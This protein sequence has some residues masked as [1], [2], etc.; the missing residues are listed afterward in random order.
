[1]AYYLDKLDSVFW[2]T[3][4]GLFFAFL[5]VVLKYCF[6]SKCR[7]VL[8]CCFYI[9]RDIEAEIEEQKLELPSIV[10]SVDNNV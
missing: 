6:K 2:L 5:G 3:L 10:G 9:E 7:K 1:M 4:G 8:C